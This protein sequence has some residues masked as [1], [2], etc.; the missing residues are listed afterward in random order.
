MSSSRVHTTFTGT[1]TC[2]RDLARLDD[3]VGGRIGAPAEAA[4]REHRVELHLLGLEAEHLRRRRL[5]D[6]LE[7]RA[8]P[9]L[10]AVA[11]HLHGAVER[12]HRRVGEERHLVFGDDRLRRAPSS[13]RGCRPSSPT[14][15]ASSPCSRNCC[16]QRRRS[17]ASRSGPGPTR[18]RARRVPSSPPRNCLP[19]TATPLPQL[20]HVRHARHRLHL[21][22][23]EGLQLRAEHRRMRDDR[24]VQVLALHV[25]AEH[26][27]AARPSRPSRC[28]AWAC[29]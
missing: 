5:V 23:V 15:P 1:F 17:R 8:H 18:P 29:R 25:E 10:G 4:A 12:L 3:V 19:T 14:C 20:D 22:G 7:L 9:D 27:L 13:P 16:R 6:A 2:L 28:A 21:V 11:A 26:R 24:G